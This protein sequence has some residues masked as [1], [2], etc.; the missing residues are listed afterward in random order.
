MLNSYDLL[1]ADGLRIK[2]IPFSTDQSLHLAV[3]LRL[4]REGIKKSETMTDTFYRYYKDG[5]L[6]QTEWYEYK[7][8]VLRSEMLE[9]HGKTK[10]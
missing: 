2:K 7:K 10:K 3:A 4:D 6:T 8:M 1:V 5:Y 9:E